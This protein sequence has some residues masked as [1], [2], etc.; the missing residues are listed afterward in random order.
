[1]E[2]T[3]HSEMVKILPVQRDMQVLTHILVMN[4]LEEMIW[5]VLAMFFSTLSK[6]HFHGKVSQAD[7]RKRNM[8][9]SRKRRRKSRLRIYVK[10]SQMSSRSSCTTVEVSLSLK[11]LIM[12]IL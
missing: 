5:R 2:N 4:N 6:D 8:L 1:M 10:T 12:A 9:L 7:L 3:S 11:T